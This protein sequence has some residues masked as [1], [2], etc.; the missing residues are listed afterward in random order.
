MDNEM[1]H[2]MDTEMGREIDMTWKMEWTLEW[3]YTVG[4]RVSGLGSRVQSLGLCMAV[5]GGCVGPRNI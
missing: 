2:E 3:W 4:F 1:E 5:P